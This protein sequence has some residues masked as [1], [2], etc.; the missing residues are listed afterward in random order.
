MYCLLAIIISERIATGTAIHSVSIYP[1]SIDIL[2]VQSVI[3]GWFCAL[4]FVRFSFYF[5]YRSD[6]K[7]NIIYLPC[8]CG[9]AIL[10]MF[11]LYYVQILYIETVV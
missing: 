11:S 10:D 6:W 5:L 2:S 3:S 4:S 1:H 9:R 7:V 8:L